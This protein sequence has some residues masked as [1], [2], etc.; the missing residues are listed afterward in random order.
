MP[1]DIYHPFVARLLLV[2]LPPPVAIAALFRH[3]PA[4][5]LSCSCRPCLCC[6][7]P[8]AGGPPRPAPPWWLPRLLLLSVVQ[9]SAPRPVCSRRLR[10]P[11]SVLCAVAPPPCRPT[12]AAHGRPLR[13]PRRRAQAGP[14]RGAQL[15]DASKQD[16]RHPRGR[17][18]PRR[19]AAGKQSRVLNRALTERLLRFR[20]AGRICVRYTPP[21]VASDQLQRCMVASFHLQERWNGTQPRQQNAGSMVRLQGWNA[22]RSRPVVPFL[23]C[24]PPRLHRATGLSSQMT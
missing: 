1:I 24:V 21:R 2:A 12:A 23:S 20:N 14:V 4:V 6:C 9:L 3:G 17:L 7:R 19:G 18:V 5:L 11:S 22:Q 16:R 10:G 15:S 8:A 13:E